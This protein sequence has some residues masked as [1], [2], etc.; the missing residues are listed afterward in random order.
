MERI[1]LK[2]NELNKYNVINDLVL[3]KINKNKTSLLLNL[4]H[5]QIDRLIIKFNSQGIY[6]FIHKFLKSNNLCPI[7]FRR[8][9]KFIIKNISKES[10]C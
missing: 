3:G 10:M 8:K 9:T 7:N 6:T 1:F 2:M 4:S 5:R